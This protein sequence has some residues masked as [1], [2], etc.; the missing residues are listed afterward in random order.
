[1]K[2]ASEQRT[3]KS[4]RFRA[5]LALPAYAGERDPFVLAHCEIIQFENQLDL[6]SNL[7]LNLICATD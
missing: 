1:M 2:G 5:F 7:D 3:Q 6:G 4:A